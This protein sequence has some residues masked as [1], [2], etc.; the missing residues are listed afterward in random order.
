MTMIVFI[1]YGGGII[2]TSDKR[3]VRKDENGNIIEV[4][5]DKETK[6]LR[7]RSGWIS[8]CGYVPFL[9]NVKDFGV[10]G[11]IETT[12]DLVNYFHLES[13]RQGLNEYWAN[14]SKIAFLYKTD[15]AIRAGLI[16]NCNDKMIM[17]CDK[18][19]MI[20]VNDVDIDSFKTRLEDEIITPNF[21]LSNLL[22][23]L[24]ELHVYVSERNHSVSSNFDVVI[25][26]QHMSE[27][28]TVN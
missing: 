15:Q 23:I 16:S 1:N 17:I 26:N 2:F 3:I 28:L 6:T 24:K 12:N 22:V 18:S 8:G 11:N 7:C 13:K 14:T 10:N 25:Y 19:V 9:E 5:S 27:I 4:V 20:L 21:E